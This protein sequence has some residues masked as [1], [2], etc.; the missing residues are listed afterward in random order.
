MR[1]EPIQQRALGRWRHLLPMCGIH[2]QF[3]TGKHGPCPMCG[4]TDR[5][6]FD[7]K[8]GRGS[9][10]C[11]QCGAGSGVDL[12]MKLNKLSFVEAKKLI[13]QHLPDAAVAMPK[14]KREVDTS[15]FVNLWRVSQPLDGTDP[16]SL[17]LA[18]R[19][20]AHTAWPSQLRYARKA[21]Y[22]HD[23]K[24]RTDHPAMVAL[25][26][27][28]DRQSSTVHF[29]YLDERGRKADVPKKRKLAPG[30]VPYGGAVRLAPSAETMG[31][32]EGI[33]TAL[34]AMRLFDVPVWAALSAG[35]LVKWQPPANVRHVLVFGDAD[36]SLAGQHAAWSLAYRL[37][38]EGIEAEVR[39]PDEIGTDW[40]DVLMGEVG[41]DELAQA[42]SERDAGRVSSGGMESAYV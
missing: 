37:K 23:D 38:T 26:V 33:E 30:K 36:K 34:S 24:T 42:H 27:S 17:Y 16:A 32:A 1:F 10:F 19:G 22:W 20:L 28:P 31:I 11:S 3:L 7:D 41:H 40:N 2:E 39:L 5:W 4:G 13:E 29:T 35:N 21:T 8:G 6:R 12:V 9:W 18:G 25:Y 14:P 15:R